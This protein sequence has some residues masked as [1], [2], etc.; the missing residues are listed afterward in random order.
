MLTLVM[1]LWLVCPDGIQLSDLLHY[2]VIKVHDIRRLDI[3]RPVLLQLSQ[4]FS[5]LD[6]IIQNRL[7]ARVEG[8]GEFGSVSH[9]IEALR[10][11]VRCKYRPIRDVAGESG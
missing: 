11:P 5:D 6:Q 1:L 10:K 8:G 9:P 3:G 2:L 7:L 4:F